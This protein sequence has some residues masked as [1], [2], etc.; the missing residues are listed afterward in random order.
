MITETKN[1]FDLSTGKFGAYLYGLLGS[2]VAFAWFDDPGSDAGPGQCIVVI[3]NQTV[4][5]H[6]VNNCVVSSCVP[7]TMKMSLVQI[8]RCD[9]IRAV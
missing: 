4:L 5:V 6:F 8:I 9:C 7:L 2:H 1:F 3:C